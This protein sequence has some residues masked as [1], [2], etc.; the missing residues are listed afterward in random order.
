[1]KLTSILGAVAWA[2]DFAMSG[3]F[4]PL[5]LG[6]DHSIAVGS[7]WGV[8]RVRKNVG[9]LFDD[10]RLNEE[11]RRL[12]LKMAELQLP[13]GVQLQ[14]VLGYRSQQEDRTVTIPLSDFSSGQVER[15]VVRL[16]MEARTL[17]EAESANVVGEIVGSERPDEVVVMGG[18]Y[19]SWD[20]GQGAHERFPGGAPERPGASDGKRRGGRRRG[21]GGRARA[22]GGSHRRYP[23]RG[24]GE[25][26]SQRGAHPVPGSTLP[27]GHRRGPGRGAMSPGAGLGP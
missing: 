9:I 22:D 1:M 10:N 11:M 25:S 7:L 16:T 21:D 13:D 15:V 3:L 19:D 12:T 14:D 20:V 24:A 2:F 6:G 26:L 8:T 18:H 4:F 17:P 27:S 5:V 23:C